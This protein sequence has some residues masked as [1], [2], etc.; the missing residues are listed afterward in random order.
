MFENFLGLDSLGS[1]KV[2]RPE[3]LPKLLAGAYRDEDRGERELDQG[4]VLPDAED[5][6]ICLAKFAVA[7]LHCDQDHTVVI[8]MK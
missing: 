8:A 5:L 6:D 2:N 1:A 4:I 7:R 3:S